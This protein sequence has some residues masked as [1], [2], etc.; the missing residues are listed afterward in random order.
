MGIRGFIHSKYGSI[1]DGI[2][3]DKTQLSQLD[4]LVKRAMSKTSLA[5]TNE[6]VDIKFIQADLRYVLEA[7]LYGATN[8][9]LLSACGISGAVVS[10]VSD[11]NTSYANTL[12]SLDTVSL[13][14]EQAQEGFASIMSDINERALKDGFVRSHHAPEF[15]YNKMDLK[16]TEKLQEACLTLWREGVVSTR[17][18]TEAHGLDIEQ[19]RER[20]AAEEKSGLRNVMRPRDEEKETEGTA[21]EGKVGRPKEND[22]EVDQA[23]SMTGKNP[24]PSTDG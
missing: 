12:V 11:G 20:L 21:T 10:G 3:P 13:R 6:L 4:T 2:V 18:M 5:T 23:K 8:N 7:D 9:Q 14:I 1:K 16:G 15:V 19:E 24:K 22:Y 17:T